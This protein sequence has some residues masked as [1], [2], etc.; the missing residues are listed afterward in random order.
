MY[1]LRVQYA[2]NAKWNR[3]GGTIDA[4]ETT[5]G[6]IFAARCAEVVPRQSDNNE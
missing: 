6:A 1:L 4:K 2:R 5:T 3:L